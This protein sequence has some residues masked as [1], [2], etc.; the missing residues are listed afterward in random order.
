MI[1]NCNNNHNNNNNKACPEARPITSGKLMELP[2][3]ASLMFSIKEGI[4]FVLR[5]LLISF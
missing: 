3:V 2:D 5:N 4:Y 1:N